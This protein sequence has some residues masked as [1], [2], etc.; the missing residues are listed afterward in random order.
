MSHLVY[1]EIKKIIKEIN[2][3]LSKVKD[4]ETNRF[5]KSILKA[6]KIVLCGAGRVGM[7]TR[8]FAMR[9][10]HLGLDAHYLGD[11]TVPSIGKGDLLIACSGSGETQSIFD[12][13]KIAKI[14]QVS[15]SLI[16][17]N[18]Y[19]RMGRLANSIVTIK[20]PS[21]TKKVTSLLSIQPMTTLNEQCLWIFFDAIVLRLMKKTGETHE[22]M[23]SRHSNLE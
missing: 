22:S 12:I 1:T 11:S 23:W 3:V 9:L 7:A 14:N 13:V 15:I 2:L 21:K 10:A 4:T 6:N 8:S 16:T 18:R 19:S 20:A 5:I 17:G